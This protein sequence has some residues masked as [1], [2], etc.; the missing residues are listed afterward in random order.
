MV[1][2]SQN[3]EKVYGTKTHLVIEI[4]L[5]SQRSNP[6]DEEWSAPMPN[7]IGLIKDE[8]Q[9]GFCYRIDMAYKEK[10]DQWTDYFYEFHGDQKEFVK[11]CKSLKIDI[12]KDIKVKEY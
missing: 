11:L 9:M 10:A 4:P 2:E 7:I 6:W 8:Y 1:I 12:V 3:K 5:V